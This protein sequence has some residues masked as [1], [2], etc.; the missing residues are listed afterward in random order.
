VAAALL[1]HLHTHTQPFY[2]RSGWI[3]PLLVISSIAAEVPL[4]LKNVNAE[5][6]ISSTPAGD[7]SQ[8]WWLYLPYLATSCCLLILAGQMLDIC[9]R[10]HKYLPWQSVDI[11]RYK[12]SVFNLLAWGLLGYAL[13][14]L[15]V[16]VFIAVGGAVVEG[17]PLGID[18]I[19]N[20]LLLFMLWSAIVAIHILPSPIDYPKV[21][22]ATL[23]PTESDTAIVAKADKA[24]IAKKYYKNIGLTITEFAKAAEVEPTALL[25]ALKR[26]KK[27]DFRGYIFHYR[28][29][30]ARNVVM[31]TDTSIAN[32][33]KRLGFNSEKF[34]SGAFLH[35]LEK[36][37]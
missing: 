25:I 29:E 18:L 10:Y 37:K 13:I 24:M 17:W 27:Q 34:L 19:I 2:N 1:H 31:H 21:F 12:I 9:R 35:Y 3:T 6:W 11:H 15:L 26:I 8:L 16:L 23:K 5:S 36:R 33:A 7:P 14:S 28:M 20:M 4:L 32:V 22:S 30:Y